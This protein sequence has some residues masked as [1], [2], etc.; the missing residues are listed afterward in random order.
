MR[1]AT[2]GQQQVPDRHL[3]KIKWATGFFRICQR[4]RVL[5]FMPRNA[6]LDAPTGEMLAPGANS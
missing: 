6:N 5:V 3:L 4:A 1:A 2:P